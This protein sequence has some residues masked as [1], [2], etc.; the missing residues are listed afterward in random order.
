MSAAVVCPNCGA[1]LSYPGPGGPACS[2]CGTAPSGQ[3]T[4]KER[5]LLLTMFM[6]FFGS[7]TTIG[8]IIT[9]LTTTVPGNDDYIVGNRLA[10]QEDFLIE[11]LPFIFLYLAAAPIAYGLWKERSW[12]RPFLFV[13][14]GISE[15]GK[16]LMPR[17]REAPAAALIPRL[18][19]SAALIGL[20]GW[21]LYR[22]RSVVGY[23]DALSVG[24]KDKK[25]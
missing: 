14:F 23:Y 3:A 18:L 6:A 25:S 8:A 9:F 1:P 7:L 24:N 16:Y 20:L 5:P 11:M 19:I 15:L 10:S 12:T 2:A 22:K 4:R 21:Y 17:W 13:F